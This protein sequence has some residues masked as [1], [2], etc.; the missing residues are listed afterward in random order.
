MSL[1]KVFKT[2]RKIHEKIFH[3]LSFEEFTQEQGLSLIQS[4]YMVYLCNVIW[5][6]PTWNLLGYHLINFIEKL[7][8]NKSIRE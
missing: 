7:I 6:N 1:M 2:S 3:S 5:A 4:N 8:K